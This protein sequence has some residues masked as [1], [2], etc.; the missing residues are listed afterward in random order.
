MRTLKLAVVVLLIA[1]F[2]LL[3]PPAEATPVT[4]SF[5]GTGSGTV[6]TQ[7]FSNAQYVIS[8]KGDTDN[9]VLGG[10][11]DTVLYSY[12]GG[13]MEIAV[14]G[15]GAA[16]IPGNVTVSCGVVIPGPGHCDVQAASQAQPFLA[17]RFASGDPRLTQ[18]TSLTS[19]SVDLSGFTAVP[20]TLRP[21]ALTVSSNLVF[22]VDIATPT[23]APLLSWLGL[24]A[25]IPT[26]VLAT[27]ISRRRHFSL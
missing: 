17:L 5:T 16:T 7:S 25:L 13:G 26:L 12:V 19:T 22:D 23:P 10:G 11:I 1:L 15:I 27:W 4:Y 2:F 20:T 18:A 3:S 21:I 9:V 14:S 8:L 24:L 6:G